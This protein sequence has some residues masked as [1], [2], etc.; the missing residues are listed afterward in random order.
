[1]AGGGMDQLQ[2]PSRFVKEIP[3]E[4]M[5]EWDLVNGTRSGWD[6]NAVHADGED[7]PDW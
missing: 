7:D 6:T 5:E 3:V 1:M 4:A 2:R